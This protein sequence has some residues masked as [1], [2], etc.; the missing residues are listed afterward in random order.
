M[1]P[2][3][4]DADPNAR[5]EFE[6][7][8][9][10]LL[11]V[12]YRT[13]RRLAQPPA[14]PGDLVQETCLRAYRTFAN[15]RRGTNGKAW[16]FTILYSV[17]V[18]AAERERHRPELAVDDVDQRFAAVVHSTGDEELALL[19]RIDSSP[20]VEAALARLPEEFRNAVVLVDVE[21]LAYEEAA[22]VLGCPVG[23]L[24]SRLSRGRKRLFLELRDYA[25]ARGFVKGGG[26]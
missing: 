9:L 1:P 26:A 16:L 6:D 18:N 8:V 5:A 19:R 11:P 12:L 15:F 14:E 3:T 25:R 21:E 4:P 13:A 17:A 22:A 10:P 24:R 20:D 7:L 23:T 2:Q